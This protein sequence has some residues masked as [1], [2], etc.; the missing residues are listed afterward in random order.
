MASDYFS[1]PF[2]RYNNDT[3]QLVDELRF[4]ACFTTE[5]IV[6][7]HTSNKFLLGRFQPFNWSE[8]LFKKYLDRWF[9]RVSQPVIISSTND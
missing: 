3:I 4:D 5:A 8:Q 6:A 1:Y 7:N 9:A 2:G